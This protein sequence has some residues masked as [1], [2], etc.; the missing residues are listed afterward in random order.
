ML[1]DTQQDAVVVAHLI[2]GE[3]VAAGRSQGQHI[4]LGSLIQP[5][6]QG[7]QGQGG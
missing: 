5:P 6:L 1:I 4:P 3:G 7:Y 2:A